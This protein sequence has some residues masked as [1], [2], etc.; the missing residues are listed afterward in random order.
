MDKI[1]KKIV[2][3]W[4]KTCHANHNQKNARVAMLISEVDNFRTREIFKEEYYL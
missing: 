3:G 1:L 4:R 2:K